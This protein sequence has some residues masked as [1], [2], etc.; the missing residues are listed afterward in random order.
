MNHC[1]I[2]IPFKPIKVKGIPKYRNVKLGEPFVDK[3]L[4]I[5]FNKTFLSS[6][7]KA[8]L[9]TDYLFLANIKIGSNRQSFNLVLDTGSYILWVPKK[10]SI[11]KYKIENHYNP[12]QSTT[13]FFTQQSFEQNYGTGYSSGYYY[14]NSLVCYLYRYSIC[15]SNTNKKS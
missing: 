12:S 13:S 8:T 2:E 7:G 3:N 11:D 1:V 15:P 10:D 6:Q 5:K 9:N 14:F 4:T